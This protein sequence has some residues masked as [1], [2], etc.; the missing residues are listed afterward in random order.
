MALVLVKSRFVGKP[1]L[2]AA[3]WSARKTPFFEQRPLEFR[4]EK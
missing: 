2:V 1:L 4:R 3:L